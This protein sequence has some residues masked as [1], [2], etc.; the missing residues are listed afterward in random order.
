MIT[1]NGK[2]AMVLALAMAAMPLAAQGVWRCG[3]NYSQSPCAGGVSVPV[4]DGRSM[5]QSRQTTEAA[6]R[7]AK[8]ADAMEKTR[9]KEE[10]KPA[11]GYIPA[12]KAEVAAKDKKPEGR[13]TE[14]GKPKKPEYFTATG[15]RKPGEGPKQKKKPTKES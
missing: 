2:A 9:L 13:K 8:T 15:P 4:E 10:A 1:T 3:N 6:Q 7:D 14:T 11:A 12:A 5:G